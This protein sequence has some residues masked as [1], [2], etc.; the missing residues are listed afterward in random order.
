MVPF[1]VVVCWWVVAVA[2]VA[3]VELPLGL[4]STTGFVTVVENVVGRP[5]SVI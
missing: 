4:P 2:E 3:V 1:C 5:S